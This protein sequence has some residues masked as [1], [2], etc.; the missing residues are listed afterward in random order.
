MA[1]T[2]DRLVN[3][4]GSSILQTEESRL[5]WW[6]SLIYA[7]RESYIDIGS[8]FEVNR[9]PGM[10]KS[11]LGQEYLQIVRGHIPSFYTLA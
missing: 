10:G 1:V 5:Q 3:R 8:T 7:V 6:H 11:G 9:E 2:A 4:G